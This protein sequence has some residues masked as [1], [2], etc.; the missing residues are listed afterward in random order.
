MCVC[1]YVPYSCSR[2]LHGI[3]HA[4]VSISWNVCFVHIIPAAPLVFK[5]HHREYVVSVPLPLKL[6]F[7]LC[8]MPHSRPLAFHLNP[9]TDLRTSHCCRCANWF[10]HDFPKSL[11]SFL[12]RVEGGASSHTTFSLPSHA[13]SSKR[14]MIYL[15]SGMKLWFLL[16]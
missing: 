11:T 2:K 7:D 5:T 13:L 16:V 4:L 9:F 1:W 3:S 14:D 12:H 8:H 6:L 15:S 10:L